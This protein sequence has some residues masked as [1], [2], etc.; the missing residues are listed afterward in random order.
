MARKR[1]ASLVLVCLLLWISGC[2][3]WTEIGVND[4]PDHG[5]IR[6]TR[7][8]GDRKVLSDPHLV[9]DTIKGKSGYERLSIPV[10]DVERVESRSTNVAGSVLLG[11]GLLLGTFIIIGAIGCAQNEGIPC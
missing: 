9:A 8:D 7:P 1:S 11:V 6:V 2:A 10:G 3:S 5:K 4:V